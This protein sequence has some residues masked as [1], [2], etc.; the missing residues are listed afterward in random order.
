MFADH[1]TDRL[2][3]DLVT[4]NEPTTPV[5]SELLVAQDTVGLVGLGDLRAKLA[6]TLHDPTFQLLPRA[7]L[8][9]LNLCR[10]HLPR[11]ERDVLLGRQLRLNS[12]RRLCFTTSARCA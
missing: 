4:G 5:G 11:L 2:L 7:S 8:D 3:T 6:R 12:S 9:V 10:V 1:A